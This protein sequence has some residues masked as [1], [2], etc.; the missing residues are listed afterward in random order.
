[1]A[2]N[3]I[4]S[5]IAII[6]LLFFLPTPNNATARNFPY[7][8]PS[9]TI[10]GE[11]KSGDGYVTANPPHGKGL[12]FGREVRNCKPKGFRRSSGPSRYVN[13]QPFG[14]SPCLTGSGKHSQP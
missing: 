3:I 10:Y 5:C 14:S 1:M 13:Y 7:S 11:T 6:F 2:S 4:I 12:P 8:G 9:T